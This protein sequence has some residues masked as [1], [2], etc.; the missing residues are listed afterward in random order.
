MSLDGILY[1]SAVKQVKLINEK[2]GLKT[3][4]VW[5]IIKIVMLIL[6]LD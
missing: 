4:N 5:N 1:F 2:Y 6:C 3:Q